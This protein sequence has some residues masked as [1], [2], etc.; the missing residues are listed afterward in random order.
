MPKRLLVSVVLFTLAAEI[1]LRRSR[2]QDNL[3]SLIACRSTQKLIFENSFVR[4]ID[5]VIPPGVSE[6]KHRHPNGVVVALEDADTET[7]LYPNG[8]AARRH[9]TKGTASWNDAIVHEV[10]NIGKTPTHFIR[11]DIK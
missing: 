11:I 6:P 2:A 10:K 9:T 5:D 8:K 1:L 7:H 3:D 4:V